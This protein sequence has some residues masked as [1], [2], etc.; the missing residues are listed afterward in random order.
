MKKFLYL[1]ALAGVLSLVSC[2]GE[3]EDINDWTH[4][5]GTS[6]VNN[7]GHAY[8]DLGLSAYWATCNIGA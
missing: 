7:N 1:F 4:N 5:Q 6:K 3:D 8:V 2:G